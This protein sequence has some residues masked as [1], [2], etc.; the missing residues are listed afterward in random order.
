M[1]L[2][3]TGLAYVIQAQRQGIHLSVNATDGLPPVTVDTERMTQVLNNLVANALRFTSEGE[4][5]LGASADNKYVRLHVSDTGTGIAADDLPNVFDRFYRADTSRQ[6]KGDGDSGL[7]L[8][9][10]KAMV[11]AHGGT[12]AVESTLGRGSVFTITLPKFNGSSGN[13]AI[14]RLMRDP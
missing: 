1:L 8:A 14:N 5:V 3:R 4:I 2:E 11:E 7:G 13:G 9:I 10:A 12:I 6:R